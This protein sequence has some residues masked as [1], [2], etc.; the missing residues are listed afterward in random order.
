MI[1][2]AALSSIASVETLGPIEIVTIDCAYIESR[3]AAS[4]IVTDTTTLDVAIVDTNTEKAVPLILSA[5]QERGLTP[6]H[7]KAILITHAHLDHAAG[8]GALAKACPNAKVYAHPKAARHLIDPSR[9]V[10][11][12]Q[13][14]YGLERFSQ[15]YGTV[16]PVDSM[17]MVP[18]EDGVTI[19]LGT[20][21]FRVF[22]T[23]GH[24]THHVAYF[25]ERSRALFTGDT[26][27]LCYPKL[28][29][30]GFFI[31]PSTSPTDFD[32]EEALKTLDRLIALKPTTLYPTHFGAVANPVEAHR[33]MKEHYRFFQ[34]LLEKAIMRDANEPHSA[35]I[36]ALSQDIAD[37]LAAF[38]RHNHL[39]FTADEMR[40]L[41]L[42]LE[43]NAQGVAYTA[44]KRRSKPSS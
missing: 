34:S 25:G 29:R 11:S 30:S 7:V 6:N 26:F 14:V 15:L 31:F 16:E 5:L 10:S 37:Y 38:A 32:P 36:Q 18:V 9:L 2:K 43:L 28:Q 44:V 4:Y 17:K 23:L 12:A 1:P 8:T 19:S 39:V 3:F 33:Q 22:Q 20:E 24:A 41:H 13:S 40:L 27:G 42:D 35:L 21:T